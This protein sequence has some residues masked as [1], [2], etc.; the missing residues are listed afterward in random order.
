MLGLSFHD[1]MRQKADDS[2]PREKPATPAPVVALGPHA[3]GPQVTE[4][5]GN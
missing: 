3:P 4:W 5:D 1:A 2:I